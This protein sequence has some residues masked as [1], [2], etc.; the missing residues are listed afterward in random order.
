MGLIIGNT[1]DSLSGNYNLSNALIISKSFIEASSIMTS[2]S[3]TELTITVGDGIID[4]IEVIVSGG[5]GDSSIWV[6]TDTLG[7]ILDILDSSPFDFESSGGGVCQ[8]WNLNYA[9]GITGLIVSSNLALVEGCYEISNPIEIS[10]IPTII[11]GGNLTTI[12]FLTEV[13]ICVSDNSSNPI[14]VLLNSNAG[15]NFQWVITDTSGLILGL[16]SSGPFDLSLAGPGLCRIWNL[17]YANGL[18]GLEVGENINNL[19]GFYNFSNSIDVTR[20]SA[21]GGEIETDQGLTEITILV[22]E[23]IVDSVDVI[24]TGEEG[25]FQIWVITNSNDIILEFGSTSPF[26]FECL[27]QCVWCVCVCFCVRVWFV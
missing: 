23:G 4:L 13:E 26:E 14:D 11:I 3:L 16:P 9:D 20:N 2:D 6:I 19:Q 27:S 7:N 17:S 1:L 15:P 10:K 21:D 18:T 25:D 12:D 24:L 22:G 8:I 5:T